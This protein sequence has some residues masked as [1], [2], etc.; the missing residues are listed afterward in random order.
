VPLELWSLYGELKLVVQQTVGILPALRTTHHSKLDRSKSCAPRKLW[1]VG[2]LTATLSS[3]HSALTRHSAQLTDTTDLLMP[4]TWGWL[5][6]GQWLA[7]RLAHAV[8]G[9]TQE[10]LQSTDT[11]VC[12]CWQRCGCMWTGVPT[13][14]LLQ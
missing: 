7:Q 2:Q 9:S 12:V 14:A 8:A 11:E 13:V 5:A 4:V 3:H 10:N 1:S 6:Q